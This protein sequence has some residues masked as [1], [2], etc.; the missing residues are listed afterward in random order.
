MMVKASSVT[1]QLSVMVLAGYMSVT[2]MKD[3]G[4]SM[5]M[6]MPYSLA[7]RMSTSVDLRSRFDHM[8]G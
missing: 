1:R 2:R 4:S 6:L 7:R 8:M 5:F 3:A